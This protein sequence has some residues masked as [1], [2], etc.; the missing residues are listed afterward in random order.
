MVGGKQVSLENITLA[1]FTFDGKNGTCPS[2]QDALLLPLRD[3]IGSLVQ[4]CL[5][6]DADAAAACFLACNAWRLCRKQAMRS[7]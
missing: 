7:K 2:L 4:T 3:L 5:A 1:A 6:L